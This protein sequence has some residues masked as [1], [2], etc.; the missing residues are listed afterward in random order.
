MPFLSPNQQRQSTESS[1]TYFLLTYLYAKLSWCW[2]RQYAVPYADN[3]GLTSNLTYIPV[4]EVMTRPPDNQSASSS[5]KRPAPAPPNHDRAPSHVIDAAAGRS[6]SS[7]RSSGFDEN[8]STV[9]DCSVLPPI[10]VAHAHD[11]GPEVTSSNAAAEDV[12]GEAAALAVD[13]SAESETTTRR[14]D[15]DDADSANTLR[16]TPAADP[17]ESADDENAATGC[18]NPPP[19][20]DGRPGGERCSSQATAA[21]DDARRDAILEEQ[22]RQIESML[23]RFN[24]M[25]DRVKAAKLAE[26]GSSTSSLRDSRETP[27]HHRPNAFVSAD[28]V[29]PRPPSVAAAADV[30]RYSRNSAYRRWIS[31]R[32]GAL[33][34]P[35]ATGTRQP[36]T[37]AAD[38]VDATTDDAPAGHVTPRRAPIGQRADDG[39]AAADG[40]RSNAASTELDDV[41]DLSYAADV[42]SA[43]HESRSPEVNNTHTGGTGSRGVV[44]NWSDAG[45]DKTQT[46]TSLRIEVC[47]DLGTTLKPAIYE[48][49][50]SVPADRSSLLQIA[51]RHR[52]ACSPDAAAGPAGTQMSRPVDDTNAGDDDETSSSSGHPS[53]YSPG[54]TSAQPEDV[55]T[56]VTPTHSVG[57]A[58]GVSRRIL[59]SLP[60]RRPSSTQPAADVFLDDRTSCSSSSPTHR[61]MISASVSSSR[62][63]RPAG[64]Y[65]SLPRIPPIR[66]RLAFRK[67]AH[68]HTETD[69]TDFTARHLHTVTNTHTDTHTRS[70]V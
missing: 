46:V 41:I 47:N 45:A 57:A 56:D 61:Q 69:L 4:N 8:S 2:C 21:D 12:G 11:D 49:E 65:D 17:R 70:Q 48:G 27:P 58:S 31:A 5:S 14:E 40:V 51:P 59:P 18:E 36:I 23:A 32:A 37:A 3:Q 64:S 25:Y 68:T 13:S 9:T 55:F 44:P 20:G 33:P 28:D 22:S 39:V 43:T 6:R 42:T 26:L 15:D 29:R 16:V 63:L 52:R 34:E 50:P 38:A 1:Y 62:R 67:P 60:A 7:S 53:R 30:A 10:S 54:S 24:T 19:G 35:E 66:R